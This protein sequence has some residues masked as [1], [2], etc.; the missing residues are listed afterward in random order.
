MSKH[1]VYKIQNQNGMAYVGSAVDWDKRQREHRRKLTQNIHPN[2]F[3]QNAWNKY[4]AESFTFEIIEELDNVQNLLHVEQKWID[5]FE[6]KRYNICPTA[7]SSL[8]TKQSQATKD[9]RSASLKGRSRIFTEEHKANLAI[10][11]RKPRKPLTE[12]H[13]AKVAA[14]NTGLKRSD[15]TRAK[16]KAAWER[17]RNVKKS[18]T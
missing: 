14:S 11:N 6:G 16:L 12:E 13:K 3:L 7:G 17:R 4:G 5:A 8:G 10:S 2:N 9:K 15:E 18:T 1:V